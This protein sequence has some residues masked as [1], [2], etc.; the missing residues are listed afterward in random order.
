[1]ILLVKKNSGTIDV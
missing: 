1:M